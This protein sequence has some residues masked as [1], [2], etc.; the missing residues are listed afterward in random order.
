M[1]CLHLFCI[2]RKL[3]GSAEFQQG[4]LRLAWHP[5][6]ATYYYTPYIL[7]KY[8]GVGVG[9]RPRHAALDRFHGSTRVETR[10]AL[11]TPEFNS[12][13]LQRDML[14]VRT[15]LD[16]SPT[17]DDLV[18]RTRKTQRVFS[19]MSDTNAFVYMKPKRRPACCMQACDIRLHSSFRHI[20]STVLMLVPHVSSRLLLR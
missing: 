9:V 20:V 4:N 13:H 17:N 7:R 12:D 6:Y 3:T 19:T 15:T 2:H 14:C 10:R 16:G 1:F 8:V 5:T 18:K 11:A